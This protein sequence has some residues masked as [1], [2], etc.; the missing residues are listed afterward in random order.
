MLPETQLS[1]KDLEK[2]A[3]V[4]S[5]IQQKH[6]PTAGAA[7]YTPVHGPGGMFSEPGIRPEMYSTLIQPRTFAES[8]PLK[9]SVIANEK[10]SILTGQQASTGTNPD[11]TCGTPPQPGLLKKCT[12]LSTF[13][14]LF[15]GSE[16]LDVTEQIGL[17]NDR[18]DLER[19]I[20]NMSNQPDPL[21]PDLLKRPGLNF[22]SVLTHQ[23]FMLGTAVRRA[24]AP[25]NVLGNSTLLPA[26]TTL[27]W[28]SEYNGLD[29][30][31]ITGHSDLATSTLCPAA[32]SF[33]LNWNRVIGGQ[34]QG[35]NI[36]ELL[37]DIFFSRQA[38]AQDVGMGETQW[39][40]VMDKRLFRAL[41]F[42]FAC[43]FANTRCTD[44]TAGTPGGRTQ[45]DVEARTLEMMNGQFLVISGQKIPVL[46]TSGDEIAIPDQSG[47]GLTGDIFLVPMK[48][49]ARDLTFYEHF[50]MNNSAL[51]EWEG[52]A[53]STKRTVL[54]NG[55]YMTAIR[56]D[57]FCDELLVS[58]KLRLRLDAPFL[59]AKIENIVFN[60]YL[61]YRDYVP[62]GTFFYDGGVTTYSA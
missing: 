56:S 32:D 16:K 27:G 42:I 38:L 30:L 61:G 31:I 12:R 37:T 33:I 55:M 23:L 40:W 28:I 21:V 5:Q 35:L 62:G 3:Q 10:I 2:I 41:T 20:Q 47:N 46:F 24:I 50:D 57:G 19:S 45:A 1:V 39:A 43:T 36:A 15:L 34:F 18:A 53:N 8:L 6:N 26:A 60:G 17:W 29:R 13:G 48:W 59:A 25:V 44:F 7:T 58:M 51:R 9:K 49:G 54:N 11:S 52:F 22:R 14:K 4:F